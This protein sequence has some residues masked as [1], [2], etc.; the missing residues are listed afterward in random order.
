MD[1]AFYLSMFNALLQSKNNLSTRFDYDSCHDGTVQ[2][3]FKKSEDFPKFF[4]IRFFQL[5]Q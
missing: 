5:H 4:Q 1:F 3:F 2:L